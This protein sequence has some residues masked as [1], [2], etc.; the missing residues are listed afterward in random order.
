MRSESTPERRRLI[1]AHAGKTTRRSAHQSIKGAHPRACGE[2]FQSA[3]AMFLI[4]GSSPRMRGKRGFVFCEKRR[5][6][7]IPAHAGKTLSIGPRRKPMPAH[8]RA[9]GENVSAKR[10]LIPKGGSS[11]R[12]RGK[13]LRVATLPARFG[14][15]PAHAGKTP[16]RQSAAVLHQAHPRACGENIS[17]PFES[18][19]SLGSSPRMR[20]KR[21]PARS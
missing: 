5:E 16:S 13:L 3:P 10:S 4:P 12:M 17:E 20:G 6:R 14:L 1:P 8:P 15:I 2:N 18:R 9:C 7:L 11:P 21:L 19:T